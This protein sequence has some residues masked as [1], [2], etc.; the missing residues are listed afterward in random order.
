MALAI[1]SVIAFL[2]LIVWRFVF[3]GQQRR[4]VVREIGVSRQQDNSFLEQGLHILDLFG[5][6]VIPDNRFENGSDGLEPVARKYRAQSYLR[7]VVALTG[8]TQTGNSYILDVGTTRFHV[9]ARYVG[10]LRDVR[11]PKCVYEETCFCLP[12]KD[13]PEAEQI[14]SALLQLRNNPALFDR[15]AAQA[16]AYKA[17]GQGFHCPQ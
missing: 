7:R 15:W 12:Y 8:A 14:A 5:V 10:R 2:A 4:P 9:R 6:A 3:N 13:M 11:Y 16:G 17:D 1:L